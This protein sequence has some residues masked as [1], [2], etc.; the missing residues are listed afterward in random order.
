MI[1]EEAI[2]V[3]A[4]QSWDAIIDGAA[5]WA[6]QDDETIRLHTDTAK[7]VLEAAAPYMLQ[8]AY[9]EGFGEGYRAGQESMEAE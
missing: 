4:K 5:P 2:Q 9:D 6:D 7:A 1:P 3:I 8:D